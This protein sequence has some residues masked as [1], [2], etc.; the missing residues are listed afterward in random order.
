ME[1][2]CSISEWPTNWSSSYLGLTSVDIGGCLI[3]KVHIN[4][5]F[6]DL[7]LEAT[8]RIF[9][10]RLDGASKFLSWKE[11]V[12]LLLKD[13]E[14]WDIVDHVKAKATGPTQSTTNQKEVKAERVIMDAT[15]DHLIPHVAENS[16]THTM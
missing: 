1:I 13:H 11:R 10:D 8:H 3:D 15:K 7:V 9:E 5:F 2:I 12:T 14:L 4:Y 6:A 16:T